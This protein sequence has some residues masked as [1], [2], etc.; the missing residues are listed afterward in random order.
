PSQWLVVLLFYRLAPLRDL[1][2][3]P[4]RRSSDLGLFRLPVLNAR[5]WFGV[6]EMPCSARASTTLVDVWSLA[7]SGV[8]GT[9]RKS[10]SSRSARCGTS[11]VGESS[12][13]W[14][15]GI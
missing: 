1:H 4:T 6:T 9:V 7:L 12:G 15:S 10:R 2:S 8:R 5:M 13:F 11:S 3:F 14:V